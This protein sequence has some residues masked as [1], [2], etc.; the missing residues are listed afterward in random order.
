MYFCGS[1]EA[2][3]V[4]LWK[5]ALG[6]F[7]IDS[8]EPLQKIQSLAIEWCSSCAETSPKACDLLLKIG[9]N[10][11]TSPEAFVGALMTLWDLKSIQ[12]LRPLYERALERFGETHHGNLFELWCMCQCR[13]S[14]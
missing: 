14:L 5:E 1:P 8:P 13:P 7:E 12:E 10:G 6:R 9:S 4:A 2:D 11:R 3:I